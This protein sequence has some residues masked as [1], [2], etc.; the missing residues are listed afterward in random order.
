MI[1]YLKLAD[2]Q[3]REEE[4]PDKGLAAPCVNTAG[5]PVNVGPYGPK[6][7]LGGGTFPGVVTPGYRY[8]APTGLGMG[9]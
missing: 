9:R 7:I 2:T 3:I 5:Q 1:Q 4:H 6:P 8:A